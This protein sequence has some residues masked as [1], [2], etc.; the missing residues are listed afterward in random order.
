MKR[1][2]TLAFILVGWLAFAMSAFTAGPF[3]EGKH[4]SRLDNAVPVRD[5]GKIEVAEIFS[6]ACGHCFTFEA[7][8]QDWKKVLPDD[9]NFVRLHVTWDRMTKNLARA[10]YTAQALDVMDEVHPGLFRALHMERKP[11]QSKEQIGQVFAKQRVDMELFNK[12][13]DSFGITSQVN[14]AESKIAGA[15]VSS[16]PTLLVDGR[17]VIN[18]SVEVN[19][20]TMLE[21]ADYLVEQVRQQRGN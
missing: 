10:L 4:Y 12:T 6:Y 13:F 18:A 20:E 9:V 5:N 21:I 2:N 16:T 14:Q 11:L 17:Y 7:V 1:L 8:V 3:V 15:R 19:H